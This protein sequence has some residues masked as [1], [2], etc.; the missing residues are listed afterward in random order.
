MVGGLRDGV[1]LGVRADALAEPGAARGA[2][3]A[4][5]AA[6]LVAV[7]DAARRAVVAGGDDA[8]V[9]RDAL[10]FASRPVS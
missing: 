5:R 7:A 4:A 2:G 9:Q 8:A 1:L 10:C 3:G 6:A